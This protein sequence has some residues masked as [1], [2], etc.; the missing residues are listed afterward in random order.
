MVDR[1]VGCQVMEVVNVIC[2]NMT[3][4]LLWGCKTMSSYILSKKSARIIIFSTYV[5]LIVMDW[6]GSDYEY[7]LNAWIKDILGFYLWQVVFVIIS[8]REKTFSI[9][10]L[11][12]CYSGLCSRT[13]ESDIKV[14][15]FNRFQE[16]HIAGFL[17]KAV[18]GYPSITNNSWFIKKIINNMNI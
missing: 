6:R 1:M 17:H 11:I 5:V 10:Y 16:E 14:Q 13:S 18:W 3:C 15:N 12:W 7:E 9:R 8:W 4:L 2:Y